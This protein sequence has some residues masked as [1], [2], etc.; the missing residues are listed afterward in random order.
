MSRH[1]PRH[2]RWNKL[3]P[4]EYRSGDAAGR[5]DKGA[6]WAVLSYRM[7]PADA[8]FTDPQAWQDRS[9]RLG[10]FKRPRNA[11]IAVE[12]YAVLLAR[13]H[14]DRVRIDSPMLK[15]V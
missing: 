10:P 14:A 8:E 2:Q 9:E 3:G 11:M 13:R 12:D 7:L 15:T 1:I 4:N 5:F 6:W